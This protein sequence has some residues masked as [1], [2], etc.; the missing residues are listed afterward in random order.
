MTLLGC[1]DVPPTE[2]CSDIVDSKWKGVEAV[3]SS[4]EFSRKW[5]L[6]RCYF[7]MVTRSNAEYGCLGEY[8]DPENPQNYYEVL[9][10]WDAESVGTGE[11]GNDEVTFVRARTTDP[12]LEVEAVFDAIPRD[13]WPFA[14][15]NPGSISCSPIPFS[16][17]GDEPECS[18]RYAWW[19]LKTISFV[20]SEGTFSF[21]RS[22]DDPDNEEYGV[23]VA[24]DTYDCCVHFNGTPEITRRVLASEDVAGYSMTVTQS[25]VDIPD[26]HD[27]Y[28]CSAGVPRACPCC[29]DTVTVTVGLEPGFTWDGFRFSFVLE[30]NNDDCDCC[31]GDTG[32]MHAVVYLP[33]FPHGDEYCTSYGV[34]TCGASTS[35]TPTSSVECQTEAV[36]TYPVAYIA[37]NDK[38]PIYDAITADEFTVILPDGLP[39]CCNTNAADVEIAE[40]V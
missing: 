7:R 3:S 24:D 36:N 21:T 26:V 30:D 39:T 17:D 11:Y 18:F 14:G 33:S 37:C 40:V 4:P 1:C 35:D 16:G 2:G 32:C 23:M 31:D 25:G 9:L 13:D 27:P 38:H 5:L 29:N 34:P 19:L 6:F 22:S 15:A 10:T 28:N 12:D 20:T 8:V